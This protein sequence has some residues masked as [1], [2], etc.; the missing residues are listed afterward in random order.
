MK[1][2]S[3]SDDLFEK[4]LRIASN[5]ISNLQLSILVYFHPSNMEHW[6]QITSNDAV[7]KDGSQQQ[8]SFAMKITGKKNSIFLVS[9][10]IKWKWAIYLLIKLMSFYFKRTKSAHTQKQTQWING[11]KRKQNRKQMITSTTDT[12]SFF[13]PEI[14]WETEC[15]KKKQPEL[16]DTMKMAMGERKSYLQLKIMS[17]VFRRTKK[18][19]K[20]LPSFLYSSD[21]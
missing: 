7:T 1:N 9:I 15:K 3:W 12:L 6:V 5:R 13:R 18:I 21:Y 8:Y 4:Y 11:G 14:Y 2:N 17:R 19:R 20:H 16:N 10:I